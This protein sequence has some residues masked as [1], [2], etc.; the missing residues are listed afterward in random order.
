MKEKNIYLVYSCNS[1]TPHMPFAAFSSKK[2][3][4]RYTT[5]HKY[6]AEYDIEEL[7]L[8]ADFVETTTKS[9][10][11]VEIG[12]DGEVNITYLAELQPENIESK[13]EQQYLNTGDSLYVYVLAED[14][15]EALKLAM[16]IANRLI[17]A[18]E[19]AFF[20]E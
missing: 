9:A 17:K 19:F 4:E 10:Y 3:A 13:L 8:D 16:E 1:D 6:N 14:Q 20:T 12:N 15:L 18:G 5:R 7:P 2:D 11:Y